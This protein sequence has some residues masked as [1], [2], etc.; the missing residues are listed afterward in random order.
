MEIFEQ[1]RN[2][3]YTKRSEKWF[4]RLKFID[5]RDLL[6]YECCFCGVSI[7]GFRINHPS[8][9]MRCFANQSFTDGKIVGYHYGTLGYKNMYAHES[10]QYGEGAVADSPS[11]SRRYDIQLKTKVRCSDLRHHTVWIVPTKFNCFR[12]VNDPKS[13]PGE[14]PPFG[15]SCLHQ[16][17]ENDKFD[18]K[19]DV[20]CRSEY[21]RYD[22]I[23][24]QR[25]RTV[26]AGEKL[27]IDHGS[28]YNFI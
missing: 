9:D 22:V 25:L 19:S 27:Y 8:Y 6:A 17:E 11:A 21:A 23:G 4:A 12:S 5:E 7:K 14:L 18:E 16:R 13:F 20:V 28:S 2:L 10:R 3:R 26:A 1:A 15:A 24:I